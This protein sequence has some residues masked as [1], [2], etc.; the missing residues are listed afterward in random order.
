MNTQQADPSPTATQLPRG[1]HGLT[2][3]EVVRSQRD[4]ILLAM[5]EAMAE[6]GYPSTSVADVLRRARVSRETFYQQFSSKEDCFR[7]A[8]ARAVEVVM[9]GIVGTGLVGEGPTDSG[10]DTVDPARLER[11]LGAYID[12]LADEPAF[13]RL[14]LVEVYAAGREVLARRAEL[15]DG[16]VELIVSILRA[17]TA[18]QR[19]ACQT[20]AA[21]ISSMVTAKIAVG[22]V[23]GLRALRS[24]LVDMV[25]RGGRLYGEFETAD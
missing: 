1:R 9:R 22:D 2:R 8:Y 20:L 13:A 19:F 16:F 10:A 15:Q 3:A 24:P 21:A 12:A 14:F 5:A 6:K 23:D 4:R 11:L 7:A 17:R 18:E 25:R